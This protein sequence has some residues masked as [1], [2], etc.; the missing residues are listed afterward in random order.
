MNSLS[1]CYGKEE[2]SHKTTVF[3][4]LIGVPGAIAGFFT[5]SRISQQVLQTLVTVFDQ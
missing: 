3:E 2:K 5:I 1:G 4:T